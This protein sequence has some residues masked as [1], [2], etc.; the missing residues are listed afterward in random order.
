M[1]QPFVL[2]A[3]TAWERWRQRCA[4]T[5]PAAY[6]A[7]SSLLGG[8]VTDPALM[9]AP[10]DDHLVHRGDGVFETLRIVSGAFY[11]LKPHVR[12]LWV[13][14]REIGLNPPM[15]ER[16][17]TAALVETARAAGRRDALVRVLLSRG[18]GGFGVHPAECPAPQVYIAVYRIG[19][20]FWEQHP[21]G[22]RALTSA[23]P[24]KAGII[25]TAKTCNYLPNALMKMEA[26]E[27]GV[28][29]T[30]SFD[31]SGGLGEGATENAAI[32][33]AD[34]VLRFPPPERILAGI[35][36]M[37]CAE[38]AGAN[39]AAFGLTG[40]VESRV[41]RPEVLAARELMLFGTSLE[42]APVVELDGRPIGTGA[43]GP[44]AAALRRALVEDMIGN[45][46]M[47]TP[48]A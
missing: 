13:S 26:A 39:P 31:E 28:D 20:P 18:P 48:A 11:A 24:M 42:V 40:V 2:D 7:Y 5:P 34:G 27:T 14:A 10:L 47:R 41:S 3:E 19:P 36:L 6:A 17:L 12:R 46:E 35:T 44:A 23:V 15:S 9:F 16:A 8:V 43:P 38:L 32:V 25:A 21:E 37:R 1:T 22:A 30:I 33:D 29:F 45:P 4:A